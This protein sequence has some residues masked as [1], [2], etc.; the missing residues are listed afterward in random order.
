MNIKLKHIQQ[1]ATIARHG[2]FN[3][4]A[5]ELSLSQ[6]ALSRSIASLE[7]LLNVP[8][9]NRTTRQIRLTHIGQIIL[10]MGMP[11]LN[12]ME[13]LEKNISS[14]I[15]LDKGKIVFGSAPYP[16]ATYLLKAISSFCE[17]YP[18]IDVKILENSPDI[19]IK[20]LLERK[21]DF[22]I[23]D[24]RFI[25]HLENYENLEKMLLP[26]EKVY[27]CCR[28]GH[29]ILEGEITPEAIR[30]Y[31]FASVPAP[32]EL[33]ADSQLFDING[34]SSLDELPVQ[35]VSSSN[36]NL[37]IGYV[38]TT[39]AI[40]MM[41]KTVLKQWSYDLEL[42]DAPFI[43][44]HTNM[45][46]VFLKHSFMYPASKKMSDIILNVAREFTETEGHY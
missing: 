16:T 17:Q 10:D 14:I 26:K 32:V 38:S 19:L 7:E 36:I 5:E 12:G 46:I 20:L 33:F 41:T 27:L 11:L 28:K 18:D 42:I 43:N 13:N 30:N 3:K 9:F 2:S 15:G 23:G 8:I 40:G 1:I 35:V 24:I 21:I 25:K 34:I 29:P 37:M 4:A 22:Y 6:P 45:A 44:I 39:N 31:P